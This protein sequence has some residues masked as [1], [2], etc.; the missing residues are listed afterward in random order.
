LRLTNASFLFRKKKSKKYVVVAC[1]RRPSAATICSAYYNK[2]PARISYLRPDS[3]ALLLHLA[4][5]GPGTRALIIESTG[6]LMTGAVAER[7]GGRGIVCNAFLGVKPPSLEIVKAFNFEDNVKASIIRQPLSKLL[8]VCKR[9]RQSHN[10]EMSDS[11]KCQMQMDT[12][13]GA[14]AENEARE[15][16]ARDDSVTVNA[17]DYNENNDDFSDCPFSSCIITMPSLEPKAALFTVLPLLA[18][19]STFA[20]LS[21]IMQPLAECM[22][23][24][25]ASECAVGMALQEV[26]FREQQMLPKRTHPLMNMNHGGGYLLSGIVTLTGSKLP[27]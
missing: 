19:S 4:N 17:E 14:V 7:L 27:V 24:L 8:E 11:P 10:E 23:A 13:D 2:T 18:P 20:M 1:A 12:S 26:W 22:H 25:R 3:L 6:G 16:A 21:P 15:M 5:V 9:A